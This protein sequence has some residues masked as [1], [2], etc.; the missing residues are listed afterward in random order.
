VTWAAFTRTAYQAARGWG[1]QPSEFWAMSVWEWWAELDAKIIENRKI[2]E[3]SGG[4][5]G[6]GT[7]TSFAPAA[8]A[9]AR[10]RH[11]EKMNGRTERA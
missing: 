2:R 1:I 5:K 4:R 7:N 8:W 6:G 11:K 10:K 3:M 9:A